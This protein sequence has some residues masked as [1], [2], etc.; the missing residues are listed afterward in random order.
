V[1]FRNWSEA[2]TGPAV[3]DDRDS[4]DIERGS[5]Y[6]AAIKLGPAHA[7]A[8]T[9]N[10]EG[11]FELCHRRDDD[12]NGTSKGAVGVDGFTLGE[13]L[14]TE[15]VQ[16]VEDLQEMLGAAGQAITGPDQNNIEATTVCVAQQSVQRRTSGLGAGD[17]VVGVLVD[18]L[19]PALTRKLAEL[20]QLRFWVLVERRDSYI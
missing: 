7:R 12:D 9:F 10:N 4:V 8:D 3:T 13:K 2:Q 16:L 15:V 19:K 6:A 1:P 5:A 14:D 18:N 11:P 17:S 20:V